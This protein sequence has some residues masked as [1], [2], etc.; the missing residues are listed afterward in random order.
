MPGIGAFRVERDGEAILRVRRCAGRRRSA[1]RRRGVSLLVVAGEASGD[2]AAAAVVAQPARSRR[3][4]AWAG[5]RSRR[6]GVELVGDLRAY[7]GAGRGRD[8][9]PRA[10]QILRA[11]RAVG[12]AAQAP[13]PRAALLVNYTEFNARLAPQLHA[14]GRARRS[15]TAR[16]RSGRGGRE[17][18]ASAAPV[19]RPDGGDAAVRGGRCGA[20]RA[21]TRTTSGTRR[22]RRRGSIATTARRALGMTP[23]AAAVAILPGSRPHEVR[24]LLVPML[25]AY[26]QLRAS[27][28]AS[29]RAFF[30]R[31]AS[32]PRRATGCALDAPSDAS[33]LRRRPASRRD[34]RAPRV[35]RRRSARRA[36]RRSKP[37]SRGPVP[38][39]AYRVG[40]TT[41]LAARMLVRTPHVA[42]PNVSSGGARSGAPAARRPRA[43]G[44]GGAGRRARP[45]TGA[46]RRVRRGRGGARRTGARRRSKWRGCSRRGWAVGRVRGVTRFAA[47]TAGAYRTLWRAD[48]PRRP[49]L[50][51]SV[52][53]LRRATPGGLRRLR[54]ALR[55]LRAAPAARVPRSPGAHRR[56]ARALVGGGT[57][58][59][60]PRAHLGRRRSWRR[61]SRGSWRSLPRVRAPPGRDAPSSP[62]SSSRSSPEIAVGLFAHDARSARSRSP[63][64]ARSRSRPIGAPRA[65]R[66]GA[67]DRRLRRGGPARGRRRARR[68][69]RASLLLVGARGAYASRPARAHARTSRPGR[70][71]WPRA[72]RGAASCTSRRAPAGRCC[73]TA[74]STPRPTR[75]SSLRNIGRAR[76]RAARSTSRRS[77]PSSRAR[78]A[79]GVARVASDGPPIGTASLLS[80]ALR[81]PAAVLVPLCLWSRV[82]EPHWVAPALLALSLAAGPARAVGPLAA[83]RRRRR[84]RHVGGARRARSTRGS[85][86]PARCSSAPAS[87]DARL[88][89]AN[90]LYGWPEVVR[91]VRDE[92]AAQAPAVRSDDVAVVGPHWVICAQLEAALARR[93]RRLRHAA[94]PTTS[95]AGGRASVGARRTS[96]VWVS[97]ARFGPPRRRCRC[98]RRCETRTVAIE[99]G[100]RV[101][102]TLH[103]HDAEPSGSSNRRRDASGTQRRLLEPSPAGGPRREAARGPRRPRDSAWSAACRR[104]RSSSRRR[105]ARRAAPRASARCGPRSGAP[106]PAASGCARTRSC[107]RGRAGRPAA[108]ARAACPATRTSALIGTLSGWR[109]EVRERPQHLAAVVD[110][111]AHADDAA[112]SRP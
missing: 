104:R 92:I 46:S 107:A 32:T 15:G 42:L 30:W 6:R 20:R 106:A 110:A 102:R 49:W 98:T 90:E 91:G 71:S 33:R 2:R 44:C 29:T 43:D 83:A 9:R 64:R 81:C 72:R 65:T 8:R 97:D 93:P 11:W 111:L 109:L 80:A 100:G 101:V 75:A 61:S 38:I 28:R 55:R 96:I 51:S 19:G 59:A 66:R 89:I 1:G 12:R 14:R 78:G 77:S 18:A 10:G 54:G 24:R 16:R 69:R 103:D 41:E 47:A 45:T 73:A 21:S 7:D 40:L 48:V 62:R 67:R 84:A 27:A 39:V 87:Y 68:R 52:P 13:R 5:R 36:P 50:L 105:R 23:Y 108:S 82:A 57:A 26:E 34:A 99:R 53:P 60:P 76:R 112:A 94:F 22:S 95:T 25:D 56:A 85:S 4:R 17:R 79:R 74:S 37:R 3:L 63:G 70:G 88:D 86:C 58:P 35:R 31:R